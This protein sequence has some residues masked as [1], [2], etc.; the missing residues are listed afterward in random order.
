MLTIISAFYGNINCR[1]DVTSQVQAALAAQGTGKATFSIYIWPTTWNINDPDSGTPKGLV[2]TYKYGNKQDAVILTQ[3]G[4]D[5]DTLTIS[6]MPYLGTFTVN[7]A[8][9]GVRG[10]A[11]D[12]TAATQFAMTY[13]PNLWQVEI[14]GHDFINNFCGGK[15]IAK[16]AKAYGVFCIEF[17]T[18]GTTLNAIAVDGQL[19]NLNTLI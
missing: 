18:N 13:F 19:L 16:P 17:V 1:V 9:Y 3:S 4:S 6:T 14:G 10:T 15:N 8:T 2:V 12:V 7:K 5:L 11:I